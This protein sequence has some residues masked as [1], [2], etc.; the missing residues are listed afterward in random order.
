MKDK[1][2]NTIK[3]FFPEE[4]FAINERHE[5]VGATFFEIRDKSSD[6]GTILA[7]FH[8]YEEEPETVCIEI[9]NVMRKTNINDVHEAVIGALEEAIDLRE[10]IARL[11]EGQNKLIQLEQER[12]GD[13]NDTNT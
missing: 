10:K 9:N 3:V 11:K 6:G 5:K 13:K 7:T 4:L 8:T 2:L 12:K 1:L